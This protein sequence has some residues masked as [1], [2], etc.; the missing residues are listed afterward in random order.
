MRRTPLTLPLAAIG[1]LAALGCAPLYHT[2]DP[3]RY[4]HRAA[5]NLEQRA[6]QACA[7]RHW[8]AGMPTEPFRTDG[9]SIWPDGMFTGETWQACCVAHDITYWCGGSEQDRDDADDELGRCVGEH[10]KRWMGALMKPGVC[11][12]GAPWI[13]AY[14]RWGYGHAYPAGYSDATE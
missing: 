14:W 5:A 9:C 8:P 2:A 6:T 1:W 10:Y 11:V 12:G 3:Y 13:P 4:D 7:D